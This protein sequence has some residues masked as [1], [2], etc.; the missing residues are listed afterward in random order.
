M[1]AEADVEDRQRFQR[2]VLAYCGL[3]VL[4]APL[5]AWALIVVPT[6]L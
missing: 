6:S 4:L 5:V 1:V 2:S 3:V